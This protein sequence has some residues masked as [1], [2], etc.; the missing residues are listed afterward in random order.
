VGA[1]S[2]KINF[3]GQILKLKKEDKMSEVEL[4]VGGGGREVGASHII[5]K[6]DSVYV[7]VDSG[8][9]PGILK[10]DPD[11]LRKSL[12][13]FS[14]VSRIDFLFL[15][16]AHLDHVGTVPNLFAI[17]PKMK[18]FCSQE[19]LLLAELQWQESLKLNDGGLT[20]S[21]FTR[22][23]LESMCAANPFNF[24]SPGQ[25]ISFKDFSVK[26]IDAGH[27]L[28]SQA[29]LFTTSSGKS[30][31]V[32]GDIGFQNR[33]V[34]DGANLDG[35]KADILISEATYAGRRRPSWK[36]EKDRLAKDVENV[37]SCGG[38]VLLAAFSFD[39]P[40]DI[41]ETLRKSKLFGR[42]PVY[43]DG[44]AQP[45][46][47]IYR[48]AKPDRVFSGIEDHFI[49]EYEERKQ[50]ASGAP[51]VVIAPN[52]MLEGGHALYYL[53]HWME[54]PRNAVFLT[55]YQAPDTLGLKIAQSQEGDIFEFESRRE[56]RRTGEVEIRVYTK[57]RKCQVS[58]YQLSAH[59]DYDELVKMW[60]DVGA[61]K[62]ILV[63]GESDSI[64][65]AVAEH[66]ELPLQAPHNG[67]KIV[68][69][70]F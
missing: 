45:A 47:L 9:H 38:H 43:I 40:P 16:H 49:Y 11:F 68:L 62:V 28:G 3:N 51:C 20:P 29:Y 15:T 46:A 41:F 55:G 17:N 37:I 12:P 63:H 65:W 13:D 10:G 35:I 8:R 4:F 34:I 70:S 24:I 56:D 48:D 27:M 2:L 30:I 31:L 6:L 18:I 59:A 58:S 61:E 5:L 23:E 64:D 57:A 69:S 19:T 22:D 42:I 21:P 44:A 25:E 66:P 26:A 67:E 39:R 1:S 54:N 53:K 50:I 32:T 33:Q 7:A 36:E 52:G 60:R 14:L